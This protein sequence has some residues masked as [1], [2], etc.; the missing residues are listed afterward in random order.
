MPNEKYTLVMPTIKT[1]IAK[2][3]NNL[4]AFFEYLPIKNIVIIGAEEIRNSM[5]NDAR[6]SFMDEKD[7]IDKDRVIQILKE[8][9]A[10]SENRAGW[11][12]QQFLKMSYSEIC[13]EDYYLIW[14]SDTI[15]VHKVSMVEKGHPVFD[16]KTEN[17]K[18]YFRTIHR[19]LPGFS[20]LG[21]KSFISEHMLISVDLMKSLIKEIEAVSKEN[22]IFTIINAINVKDLGCGF[23]EFET[24]GTYVCT[25]Y[26][27]LYKQR[28]WK[29]LRDGSIFFKKSVISNKERIW[30]SQ[31]YD[32]ISFEKWSG[33]FQVPQIV[34]NWY[35]NKNISPKF[36]SIVLIPAK[37][38]NKVNRI[39]GKN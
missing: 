28:I 38:M 16:M 39:V 5:P 10:G 13:N 23:S 24:Y 15:P 36:V 20:K 35:V 3:I 30:L 21:N 4:E 1:D 22:Y 2:I 17:H 11:Y 25:K 27:K 19:I 18:A 9:C 29:S 33:K 31:Y 32:A 14:D 8:R 6:L 26:P 7:I 37:I 12:Y 34:S